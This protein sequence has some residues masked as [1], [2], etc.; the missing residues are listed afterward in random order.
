MN[1]N[2]F[3]GNRSHYFCCCIVF[4]HSNRSNIHQ[5]KFK[6][7]MEVQKE[8]N[9]LINRW[10]IERKLRKHRPNDV[11]CLWQF[12]EIAKAKKDYQ[13]FSPPPLVRI[14]FGKSFNI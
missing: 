14:G 10:R 8:S 1:R 12:V 2:L 6:A 13:Q 5:L 7:G 11:F 9:L 4:Y 3:V